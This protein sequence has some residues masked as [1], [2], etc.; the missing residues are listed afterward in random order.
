VKLMQIGSVCYPV[1]YSVW[2]DLCWDFG[3]LRLWVAF[4]HQC[5]SDPLT[6]KLVMDCGVE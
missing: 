6:E 2:P 4:V 3:A 5:Q 1:L